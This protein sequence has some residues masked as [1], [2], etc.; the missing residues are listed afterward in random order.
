[1]RMNWLRIQVWTIASI[2][3]PALLAAGCAGWLA[4]NIAT[5]K[6]ENSDL[7]SQLA[8]CQQKDQVK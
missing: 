3:L 2:A 4:Y 6:A 5:L 8:A 1:M 7:R